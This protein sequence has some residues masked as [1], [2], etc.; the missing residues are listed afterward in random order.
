MIHKENAQDGKCTRSQQRIV[1]DEDSET[2]YVEK[3]ARMRSRGRT[4][5]SISRSQY[6][7][8]V[9]S[10]NVVGDIDG[11]V[12]VRFILSTSLSLEQHGSLERNGLRSKSSL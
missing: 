7:K 3:A 8:A 11:G 4:C 2:D 5:S 10:G 6:K 9:S 1:I 12:N